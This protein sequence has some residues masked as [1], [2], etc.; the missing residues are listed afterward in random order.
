MYVKI[1]WIRHR[2]FLKLSY[3][4]IYITHWSSHP[5]SETHDNYSETLICIKITH[6]CCW[7]EDSDISG[8]SLTVCTTDKPQCHAGVVDHWTTLWE[9]RICALWGGVNW[10]SLKWLILLDGKD[11]F[12]FLIFPLTRTWKIIGLCET[13]PLSS[14]LFLSRKFETSRGGSELVCMCVR[15]CT[16]IRGTTVPSHLH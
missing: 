3:L 14:L 6:R 5:N 9:A 4:C 8:W 12:K 13:L 10:I 1:I 7:S 16:H 15:K 11:T 2:R